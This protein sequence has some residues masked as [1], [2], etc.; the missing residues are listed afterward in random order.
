M[1]TAQLDHPA[2]LREALDIGEEI[3]FLFLLLVPPEA[4]PSMVN[5]CPFK[6]KFFLSTFGRADAQ[7][8]SNIHPAHWSSL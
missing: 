5:A 3:A 4:S 7:A 1:E 2:G 8:V 6:P